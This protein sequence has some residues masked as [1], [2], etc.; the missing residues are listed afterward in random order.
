MTAGSSDSKSFWG[1]MPGIL[2]AIGGL[3]AGVAALI[4]A[5]TAL[6]GTHDPRNNP[7]PNGSNITTTVNAGL[8]MTEWVEKAS[9]ACASYV[10]QI[11]NSKAAAQHVSDLASGADGMAEIA[12]LELAE[13]DALVRL[14]RPEARADEVS[15]FLKSLQDESTAATFAADAMRQIDPHGATQQL[16]DQATQ[17]LNDFGA[18]SDESNRYA[19]LLGVSCS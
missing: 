18:T 8:T 17:A 9:A 12:R 19:T 15:A 2:T 10:P 3:I 16:K 4:T 5:I 14:P 13:H 7:P 1:T 6:I 11:L